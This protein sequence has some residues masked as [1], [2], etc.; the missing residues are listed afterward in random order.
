MNTFGAYDVSVLLLLVL[1]GGVILSM[2]SI[3]ALALRNASAAARHGVW[4]LGMAGVLALP[5]ADWVAPSWFVEVPAPV[6]Q[7]L[8]RDVLAPVPTAMSDAVTP[9]NAIL[10]DARLDE[11]A[12]SP[13]NSS[14]SAPIDVSARVSSTSSAVQLET[15]VAAAPVLPRWVPR[16]M[17]LGLAIWALGSAVL[18]LV[19]FAGLLA[20]RSLRRRSGAFP[21]GRVSALARSLAHEM[22]LR[23]AVPVLR[24]ARGSMPMSWGLMRRVILLP[25]DAERWAEARLVAVLRHELAH[26]RRRDCLTQ[27]VAEVSLALHWPNPLAWL[28]ARRLRVE[29]EHACD[30]AVVLAGARPSEYARALMDLAACTAP[31]PTRVRVAA[32]MARPVHLRGRLRAILDE[33][34]VRR[35]SPMSTLAAA[36][37]AIVLVITVAAFTPAATSETSDV[38]AVRAISETHLDV[39]TSKESQVTSTESAPAAAALPVQ[40]TTEA[41]PIEDAAQQAGPTYRQ[42]EGYIILDALQQTPLLPGATY[43]VARSVVAERGQIRGRITDAATGLPLR[44]ARVQRLGSEVVAL[45]SET[46]AYALI[47]VPAGTFELRVERVG[48]A[49]QTRQVALTQEAVLETDFALVA[50]TVAIAPVVITGTAGSAAR[51]VT[52]RMTV[53][54][55]TLVLIDSVQLQPRIRIRGA[56]APQPAP[57]IYI[58]GVRISSEASPLNQVNPDQIDRIEIIKGEAA[59]QRYGP[60]AVSGVILIFLK[61]PS[62]EALMRQAVPDLDSIIS[63]M[64]VQ[65]R[66]RGVNASGPLLQPLVFLDGV[67]LGEAEREILRTL[68]A[69]QIDR[70]E[71]I[72]GSAAVQLYGPEAERGVV[73]VFL[74]RP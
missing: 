8:P 40:L 6:A 15:P 42:Q 45:S 64:S 48:Y 12:S 65:V 7:I 61:R 70:I 37:T 43:S 3:A 23:E 35:V 50:E 46:G 9:L 63:S 22:G 5:L 53:Q 55:D 71:V 13:A 72:K 25:E 54:A 30:D 36:V 39:F 60:E 29:R 52:G 38:I 17:T 73:Q 16:A 27:A 1:K 67:Q 41:K 56:E 69:D 24:G 28:A 66:L 26:V 44:D 47:D 4:F 21:E 11:T 18:L 10:G 34:R 33:G 74:K 32:A 57:I 20:L 14:V 51:V 49:T 58:D 68:T 59:V 31:L 19:F 2:A 62:L